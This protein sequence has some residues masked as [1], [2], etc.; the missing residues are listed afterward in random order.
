MAILNKNPKHFMPGDSVTASIIND[1]IDTAVSANI[2]A[3]NV[4]SD[5]QA[6]KTNSII[7]LEKATEVE[8]RANSGEFNAALVEADGMFGFQVVNGELIMSYSG[9]EAPNISLNENGELVY[10]F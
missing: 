9:S 5:L 3:N 7:A 1:T 8:E 2:T 4:S 10:N 6:A